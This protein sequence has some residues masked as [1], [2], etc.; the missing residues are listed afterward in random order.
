MK[1][2]LLIPAILCLFILMVNS[3][4]FAQAG[5]KKSDDDISVISV[6]SDYITN[7]NEFGVLDNIVAQPAYS[8]NVSY[9]GKKGLFLYF[10]PYF[11]GNSDSTS[12]KFTKEY[13]F[14]AGYNW[15]I[16]K[17]F[18]ITPSYTHFIFDKN[19]ATIKSGFSDYAQINT[20]LQLKW[21]EA[22]LSAG[23]GWGRTSDMIMIAGTN[24]TIKLDHFLGHGNNLLIQPT[25]SC[26]F[27]KN[28]LGL[29]NLIKRLNGLSEFLM[30]YP[31]MTASDYLNSTVPA[32]VTWRTNHPALT[33]SITNKLNKRQAKNS[34]KNTSGS[35]LLSDLFPTQKANFGPT[36]IVISLP[37][38]YNLKD[39]AFDTNLLYMKPISKTNLSQFYVSVG[40]TYSFGL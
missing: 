25:A 21:W 32:I 13:D 4:A 5:G 9:D 6:G 2:L 12:S 26:L 35:I 31:T 38:T 34:K 40:F 29:L 37:V 36:S 20:S 24:A 10:T 17:S 14:E 22:T 19:S 15:S 33:A 7:R 8:V 18:T 1:H 11:V 28:Q 23:Y 27:S 30:L 3:A 16:S 39:F